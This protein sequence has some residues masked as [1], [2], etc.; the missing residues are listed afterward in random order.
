[1]NLESIAA[2][3][4]AI[5]EEKHPG[6]KVEVWEDENGVIHIG[7]CHPKPIGFITITFDRTVE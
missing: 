5:E 3:I 2:R 1:M 4:K 7:V 6:C